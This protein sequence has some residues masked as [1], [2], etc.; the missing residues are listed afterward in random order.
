MLRQIAALRMPPGKSA[1]PDL[2]NALKDR[3]ATVRLG[4]AV[5]LWLRPESKIC[6]AE[7]DVSSRKQKPPLP[8][9][10]AELGI[11]MTPVSK[12]RSF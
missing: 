4:A 9:A 8:G 5:S 6:P 3:V 7:T 10:R 11:P 1:L 12:V 2:V